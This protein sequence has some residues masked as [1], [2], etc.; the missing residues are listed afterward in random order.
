MTKQAIELWDYHAPYASQ[1]VKIRIAREKTPL[2]KEAVDAADKA[3]QEFAAKNALAK[4][5]EIAYLVSYE[6][7]LGHISAKV[8]KDNYRFSQYLNRNPQSEPFRLISNR[9]NYNPLGSWILPECENGQYVLFGNKKDF[10]NKK[11]SAFGG[12]TNSDDE[13]GSIIS[14]DRHVHRKIKE[15]MGDGIEKRIESSGII[16]LDFLPVIGTKGFDAV[17][18]ARLD[19]RHE[20][21][22]LEFNENPQFSKVVLPVGSDPVS[23]VEFLNSD[24]WEPTTSCVGGVFSYIGSR[25]GDEELEKA[26]KAYCGK[27]DVKRFGIKPSGNVVEY[28][29]H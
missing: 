4:D 17:Y 23:L 20:S 28:M 26:I 3:W 16:G 9:S 15:E 5:T 18:V 21:I 13:D 7:D 19:G 24:L 6:N 22:T 1:N 12:F 8:F 27:V 14:I 25:H 29:E 10:G 11:V 2:P